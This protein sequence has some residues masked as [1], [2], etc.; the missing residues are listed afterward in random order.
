M[1]L[2]DAK[3]SGRN[4]IAIDQRVAVTSPSESDAV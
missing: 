2:Y 1:A 3:G 4:R